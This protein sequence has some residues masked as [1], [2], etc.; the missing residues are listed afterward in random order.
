M[1][2]LHADLALLLTAVIWGSAF[3]FQKS[4]MS[5]IGPLTFIAAR[6]IV[7]ALALTPLALWERNRAHGELAPAETTAGLSADPDPLRSMSA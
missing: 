2:R 5:H 6:G 3:V 7:A 4:A 1:R